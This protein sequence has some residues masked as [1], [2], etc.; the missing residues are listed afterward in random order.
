MKLAESEQMHSKS[1][2]EHP[3]S[4]P[5]LGRQEKMQA[6]T[7]E[8]NSGRLVVV[9]DDEVVVWPETMPAE[10]PRTNEATAVFILIN[11][12]NGRVEREKL[13]L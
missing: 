11:W 4:S 13:R 6:G 10:R 2:G 7:A 1:V 12:L 3:I 9:G 8:T 5:T